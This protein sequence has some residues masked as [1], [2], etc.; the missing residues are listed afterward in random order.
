MYRQG[1]NYLHS[2]LN[3]IEDSCSWRDEIGRYIHYY[4]PSEII[5][6]SKNMELTTDT[7][8]QN[9]DI[10]H[11]SI[12]INLYKD[13]VFHKLSYQNEFLQ[14]IF[15]LKSMMSPIEAF[16]LE[17]NPELVVSYIYLLK[18]VHDHRADILSNIEN[19]EIVVNDQH[20]CLTSNSIRQ[21]NVINNYSYF[22]GKNESLLSVTNSCVTPMGRRLCKERLLYPSINP[23]TIN[24]RYE[25]IDMFRENK[26]YEPIQKN[27]RKVSD[28]ERSLR[29]MGMA[30]LQPNEFFCDYLSFEYVDS[31][32]QTIKTN[33]TIL[34][35]YTESLETILL[36]DDFFKEITTVF[37]FQ[38][39]SQ[40]LLERS[41]FCQSYNLEIDSFDKLS[42]E[43]YE[44]ISSISKRF[45]K[46]LDASD[47][48]IKFDYDD[49]NGWHFYC[50]NKRCNDFKKKLSNIQNHSIHVKDDNDKV[51][52]SF[53]NNDFSFKKKDKSNMIIETPYL[54]EISKKLINVQYKLSKK[55]KE[56]WKSSIDT[57]YKKWNN[58]LKKIYLF[59]AN[60]DVYC[61]GAKI[62]IQNGYNKPKIQEA[63]KSFCRFQGIRHPIVEKIHVDTEYVT[64]DIHL[65]CD[66]QDGILLFGT[67]A[68]GKSTLMK[69]VGLNLI[70]AQAGFFVASKEFYYKP[71]TQ[72]F[73]RILNNDN[74]FRSQSSFAVEVQELKSILNRAD[75][76]SLILGDEL[77]SGTESISALSII[78]SGLHTLCNRKSSFIF[79]SH[80]HQLTELEEIN[81]LTNLQV[82]HLRIEYDKEKNILVYDRK[83]EKGSGPSI[84]GLIVCEAMGMTKDFVSYAKQIQNKLTENEICD[85]NYRNITTTFS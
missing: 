69:A 78:A 64:N 61:S 38:N 34:D 57:L 67:N 17:K 21:L 24:Q 39:I 79:T 8:I 63:E 65:G 35:K 19:P 7:I 15:K 44:L 32:F 81:N 30:L 26:F 41:I 16:D 45:S 36:F 29:K 68:C 10:S 66:N 23:K 55:N 18:Y 70:L 72:I 54:L 14:G 2:I 31:V 1:K 85:K 60:I 62:S 51:V 22:K 77:C 42:E 83:L 82:Y 20:L 73:T 40:S 71:Y 59:I 48:S 58:H 3:Y 9:W 28:L 6:H 53:K 56:L 5:F 4:N 37:D 25:F 50:T 74:I 12:Q 52:V 76:Y 46:F 75:S 11:N 43:Y 13:N 80:L 47:T 84:Y 49:R 27:L 33:E